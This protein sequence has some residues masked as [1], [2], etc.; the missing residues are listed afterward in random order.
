MY[1]STIKYRIATI[2]YLHHWL[3][4]WC[5]LMNRVWLGF[6]KVF[7]SLQQ[8]THTCTYTAC[9]IWLLLL[10]LF[11]LKLPRK[12]FNEGKEINKRRPQEEQHNMHHSSKTDRCAICQFNSERWASEFLWTHADVFWSSFCCGNHSTRIRFSHD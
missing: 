2:G 3:I 12:A 9:F 5:S 10:F 6:I 8:M 7:H 11:F 1:F 4:C